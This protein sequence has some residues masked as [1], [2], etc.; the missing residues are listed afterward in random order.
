MRK[1]FVLLL[2]YS[3][4]LI[5]CESNNSPSDSK[6][7]DQSTHTETQPATTYETVD[8]HGEPD[9]E[10]EGAY[11]WVDE[12]YAEEQIES[13]DWEWVLDSIPSDEYVK[14]EGMHTTPESATLYKDGEAVSLSV[15]DPRLVKLLNFYN[16]AVSHCV[17]SYSQGQVNSDYK[18]VSTKDFRLELTFAVENEGKLTLENGSSKMFV[19]QHSFYIM[20]D[21]PFGDYAFSLFSR[22]P[23]H[24]Y[25]LH[26]LTIF[27]F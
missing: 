5:S 15:D 20:I 12:L 19:T 2:L 23:L 8:V 24:A 13:I 21:Q 7:M 4:I 11:V 6:T 1:I 26:W 9:P 3:F 14:I 18:Y 27:G 25:N 17:Y 16:N 10:H 22:N